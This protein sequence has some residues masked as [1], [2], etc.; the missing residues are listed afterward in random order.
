[1]LF[2]SQSHRF[3]APDH[4]ERGQGSL[5]TPVAGE[6]IDYSLFG[7][8]PAAIER[9]ILI[10]CAPRNVTQHSTQDHPPGSVVAHNLDA[11]YKPQV[12]APAP[13]P[14]D[15][16]ED[17]VRVQGWGLDINTK[18]LRWESY[19]KAGYYVRPYTSSLSSDRLMCPGRSGPLFRWWNKRTSRSC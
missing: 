12:F 18:E 2:Y 14:L 6:H 15:L 4:N 1:M 5:L 11:K 8:L 13:K 9:D 7:V 16:G 17:V 3:V 19:V 10:A